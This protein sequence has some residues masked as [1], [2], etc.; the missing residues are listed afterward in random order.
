MSSD[1]Q[2]CIGSLSSLLATALLFMLALSVLL[3]I[4][5]L[6]LSAVAIFFVLRFVTRRYLMPQFY[7]ATAVFAGERLFGA[8]PDS[9]LFSAYDY[10]LSCLE[11]ATLLPFT[12]TP[13][14]LVTGSIILSLTPALIVGLP[15]LLVEPQVGNCVFP[16]LILFGVV[17]GGFT[18][19]RLGQPAA[20]WFEAL[21]GTSP[22]LN[23]VPDG[24]ITLGEEE[25]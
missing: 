18:G 23:D 21:P 13:T 16:G 6:F 7:P 2:G 5:F 12:E 8:P 19:Y 10:W 3:T 25:W 4:V 15:L 22:P 14:Q 24:G 1:G 20:G 11:S 9:Q 17:F